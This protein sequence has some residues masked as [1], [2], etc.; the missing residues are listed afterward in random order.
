MEKLDQAL[1]RSFS[2]M[3]L[4]GNTFWL[5][6]TVWDDFSQYEAA[7]NDV[8]GKYKMLALCTYSLDRCNSVE[9]IDV[10]RNHQFALIK[11]GGR[12]ELIESAI[13]KKAKEQIKQVAE[14]WQATFDSV[15]D[16]ISI[17][18]TEFKVVRANKAF[19][20]VVKMRPEEL[21]GRRCFEVV[22]GTTCPI[23]ECPHERTLRTK[24]ASSRE[25]FEPRLGMYLELT[26]CPIFT[27]SGELMGSV[28]I[29][30]DI[31]VRKRAEEELRKHREHL[32]ELVRE[33][34]AEL[35]YYIAKATAAHE[36]ERKR[37]AR[38]L[39]DD[40]GQKLVSLR[41]RIES[42]MKELDRPAEDTR[43]RLQEL[44][45]RTGE[46]MQKLRLLTRELRPEILEYLGLSKALNQLAAE[47][48]AE[49]QIEV[50]SRCTGPE[51]RLPAETELALY[52]IVQEALNNI[53][54]HSRATQAAVD[55][56]FAF[57]NVKVAVRDNG[58]GFEIPKG[59]E[60]TRS[61]TLGLLSMHERARLVGAGISIE[62][63]LNQGTT[64]TVEI[65]E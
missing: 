41:L 61:T 35:R 15:G 10:V 39:H 46:I 22:H 30:K 29:A 44:A 9:V 18:D 38:E 56:E 43:L 16:L 42:L 8:I 4:T 7:V 49:M 65:G 5:E 63:G 60:L 57:R 2:G 50:H 64:V 59:H 25:V 48:Q 34:T 19:A 14:E 45:D 36:E 28:H 27:E 23:D 17:H 55:L 51:R 62:S 58:R 26:T 11:Q 47:L 31:T 6:K 3:R 21:T 13:Y 52:R 53:R 54:K 12:W 37:I 1:A 40:T 20:E 33:R 32:E 24:T